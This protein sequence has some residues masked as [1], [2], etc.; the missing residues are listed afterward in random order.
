MLFNVTAQKNVQNF[1]KYVLFK[2]TSKELRGHFTRSNEKGETAYISAV[3]AS[4][5][6]GK[7]VAFF[8]T[9]H[10]SVE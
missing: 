7:R 1:G 8:E 5:K 10:Y 3:C 2:P 6:H 4:C 9:N